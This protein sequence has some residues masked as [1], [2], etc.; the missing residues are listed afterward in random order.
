MRYLL[1]FVLL[2]STQSF[3]QCKE[4]VLTP[5]GD[6]LNCVDMKGQRQGPWIV[7]VEGLRGERGYEEEGFYKNGVKEGTWRRYSLEGDVI[8]V[9]NYRWGQK[10]GKNVYFDNMGQPLRE[11]S[12][13]AIDP[14]SPFDT[15]D[16][17]DIE[18]PTKIHHK[19]VIRVEPRPF[20]HGVWTYYDPNRGTVEKREAFK[21]DKP[22]RQQGDDLIPLDVS[23]TTT[24]P[25]TEEK[26]PVTKPKE[27]LEFEKKNAGKKKIKVK[28]GSAG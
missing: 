10:H 26:K 2:A 9:E 21:M 18:D 25:K 5:K 14:G 7:K 6:T 15:I 11:E 22:A 13:R 4:F 12:W 8:A 28:D 1:F 17:Y 19:Q 3:A 20:K 27:V 23:D 24:A 16:V